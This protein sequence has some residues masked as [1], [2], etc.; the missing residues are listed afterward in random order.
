MMMLMGMI[1]IMIM[2]MSISMIMRMNIIHRNLSLSF[3][4]IDETYVIGLR[5]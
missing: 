4:K 5:N 2:S 1:M 3:Y